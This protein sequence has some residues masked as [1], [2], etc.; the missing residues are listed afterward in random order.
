MLLKKI[1]DVPLKNYQYHPP[2]TCSPEAKP[3]SLV[4]F[5]LVLAVVSDSRHG[6]KPRKLVQR[7]EEQPYDD[8]K[9]LESDRRH[10]DDL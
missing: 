6:L 5:L 7:Q 10:R 4:L 9:S 8:R 3:W 1:T 2:N